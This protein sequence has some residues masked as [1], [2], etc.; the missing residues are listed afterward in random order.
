MAGS[1][2]NKSKRKRIEIEKS[3]TNKPSLPDVLDPSTFAASRA[4]EIESLLDAMK[5]SRMAASKRVFQ[6]LPKHL[7]RRV[8]SHAPKR[9]PCNHRQASL[10]E[11][12][13]VCLFPRHPP[14]PALNR[15][16]LILSLM[17]HNRNNV[18]KLFQ[19]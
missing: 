1:N 7:R 9:V 18:P 6:R 12:L 10:L 11:V 14:I 13:L 2:L 5:Q 4:S 3:L 8:A 15:N 16:S 17:I 19:Q